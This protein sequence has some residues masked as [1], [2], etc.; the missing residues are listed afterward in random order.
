MSQP[1][2]AK[3]LGRGRTYPCG[4]VKARIWLS[5]SLWLPKLSSQRKPVIL[6]FLCFL[7]LTEVGESHNMTPA[8]LPHFLWHDLQ[9]NTIMETW[10]RSTLLKS[11][12]DFHTVYV[13]PKVFIHFSLFFWGPSQW[14]SA[15]AFA[16][17]FLSLLGSLAS[18]AH[19]YFHKKNPH[20]HLLF[21]S[22]NRIVGYCFTSFCLLQPFSSPTS[23]W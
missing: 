22:A 18:L 13:L 11:A 15:I 21:L 17:C 10:K 14:P 23:F 5:Q 19:T 8:Q 2:G 1:C 12:E 6:P 7:S 20:D 9:R 16:H 3:G 4:N